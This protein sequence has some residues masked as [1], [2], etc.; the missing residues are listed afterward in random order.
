MSAPSLEN[1]VG[2]EAHFHPPLAQAPWFDTTLNGWVLSRYQDVLAAFHESTMQQTPPQAKQRE[3]GSQVRSD[4]SAALSHLKLAH[5]EPRI[6]SLIHTFIDR[7]PYCREIDLV[8]ELIRP[9]SLA[10]LQAIVGGDETQQRRVISVAHFISGGTADARRLSLRSRFAS[11]PA[12]AVRSLPQIA[13]LTF[14]QKKAQVDVE[15]LSRNTRLP[16]LKSVILGVSQ[17]LPGFLSNAWLA[18]MRH[19]EEMRRLRVE[20]ALVPAAVE[21]LLRHAGLV[22]TLVRR[23]SANVRVAGVDV[24]AGQSVILKIASANHDPARFH[25]PNRLIVDRSVR[26]REMG[27]LALGAGPHYCVGAQF[28]RLAA[29]VATRAFIEKIPAIKLA[30]TVEWSRGPVLSFPRTLP[31]TI[32]PQ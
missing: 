18:L 22:H 26:D 15:R 31:A 11:T 13:W 9:W 17:T 5:M 20:P 6:A 25:E 29:T 4:V 8:G 7:V 23:A 28:V 32:A 16:G 27:Q 19:P 2:W 12:A 24:R 3:A 10:L 1:C 30:G 21:E 14:R